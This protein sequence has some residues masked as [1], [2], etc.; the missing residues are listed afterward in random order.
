MSSEELEGVMVKG[1]VALETRIEP[2][3]KL[4]TL[5]DKELPGDR[6]VELPPLV[7]W[8]VTHKDALLHVRLQLLPLVLLHIDIGSTT[9]HPEAAEIRLLAFPGFKGC[10]ARKRRG[11]QAV[12]HLD[13]SGKTA[14]PEA[15]RQLGLV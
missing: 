4:R 2:L 3:V 6:I 12:P 5:R 14:T 7:V 8:R 9:K 11:G 15:R 13:L 1:V 10:L